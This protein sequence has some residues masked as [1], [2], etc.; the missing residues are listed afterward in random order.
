M[1]TPPPVIIR[2]RRIVTLDP[3]CPV[4]DAVAVVDGRVLH[5]GTFEEV[6]SDLAGLGAIVDDRFGDQVIVPGF[7][8]GHCHILDEGSLSRF[9]WLGSY[10]RRTPDGGVQPG[11]ATHDAALARIVRAAS[12]TPEPNDVVVCLGWDPAM[13]GSP[14]LDRHV[15]DA[16]APGRAVYV[17]QSNGHVGHASSVLLERAGVSRDTRVPGVVRDDAGEPTGTLHVVDALVG[18]LGA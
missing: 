16:V 7:I 6:S 4:A 17:H 18:V 14:G 9:A 8:E 2:A 13:A 1:P 10:D 11:C 5:T 15:L 3:S 12:E